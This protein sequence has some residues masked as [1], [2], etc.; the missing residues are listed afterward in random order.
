MQSG[1]QIDVVAG[2]V[3]FGIPTMTDYQQIAASDSSAVVSGS[4]P[5]ATAVRTGT[6]LKVL[7]SPAIYVVGTNGEA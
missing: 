5:T 4:F 6:L 7:G 2:G 1:A 3:G